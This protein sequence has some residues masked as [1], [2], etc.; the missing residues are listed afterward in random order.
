MEIRL[1]KK[2]DLPKLETMYKEIVAEMN[3]NNLFIWNEYYPYEEFEGDI[4]AKRLYLMIDKKQ[5][6]GAFVLLDEI[7]GSQNFQWEKPTAKSMYIGRLGIN[8]H[9][10]RSGLGSRLLMFAKDIVKKSNAQYLRLTVANDNLPAIKLY[11]KNGFYNVA[12][13]YNEFS[14]TLNKTISEIGFEFKLQ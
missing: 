1:A 8:V 11:N 13:T 6:I 7:A 10:L 14:E 9:Y 2:D 12:G 5:I 4:N 3:N